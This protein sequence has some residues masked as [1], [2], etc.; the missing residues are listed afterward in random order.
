MR[1][2]ASGIKVVQNRA[3]NQ[4]NYFDKLVGHIRMKQGM[5]ADLLANQLNV[6]VVLMKELLKEAEIKGHLCRDESMEGIRYYEN[7]ISKMTV[8]N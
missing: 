8:I 4:E 5:T 3:F 6:N 7:L 2:F 1:T